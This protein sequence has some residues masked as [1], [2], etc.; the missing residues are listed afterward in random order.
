MFFP[1]QELKKELPGSMAACEEC[2]PEMLDCFK[3]DFDELRPFFHFFCP[4]DT[5]ATLVQLMIEKDCLIKPHS[6]LRKVLLGLQGLQ[7][8]GG[9][10]IQ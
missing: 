5:L 10:P 6:W 1:D 9:C 8:E 2:L 4:P 3:R 7:R